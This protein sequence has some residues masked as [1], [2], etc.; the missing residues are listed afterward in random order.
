MEPGN[1]PNVTVMLATPDD[2]SGFGTRH[3]RID[4]ATGRFTLTGV[5][6]GSYILTANQHQT[7]PQIPPM[8]AWQPIEVT[9]R[10][11]QGNLM[12]QKAVDISG[13]I[14]MEGDRSVPLQNVHI[15]MM[16]QGQVFGMHPRVEMQQNGTLTLKNMVPGLWRLTAY[17]PNVFLRAI[18][19]G[20][21]TLEGQTLDTS[22]GM[23]GSL[24]FF[25]STRTA[26]IQANGT[27]G[28]MYTFLQDGETMF[29]RPHI[30]HADP[31]GA[32]KMEGLAPGK[33]KVYEGTVPDDAMFLKTVTV[34]EA[35][36]VELDL[37]KRAASGNAR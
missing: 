24:R 36:V 26:T 9:D 1:N 19:A 29:A 7:N 13:T 15:Q 31:Q 35:A 27:P 11:L 32:L 37:S 18:E 16:P 3:G 4:P 23:P 22:K 30:A 8:S 33:Y 21:Q 25:V 6:P 28:L 20:G 5:L 17:G 12:M 10:S 14:V 2:Q 34:A